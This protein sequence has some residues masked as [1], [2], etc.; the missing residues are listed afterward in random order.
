MGKCWKYVHDSFKV[1]I[2][3]SNLEIRNPC[4]IL[5][6]YL[7]AKKLNTYGTHVETS[8]LQILVDSSAMPPQ[9]ITYCMK[10]SLSLT[11]VSLDAINSLRKYTALEGFCAAITYNNGSSFRP[12]NNKDQFDW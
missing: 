10:T 4:K 1:S 5:T 12:S 2:N 7:I 3:V 8:N 6:I 11:A 9:Y